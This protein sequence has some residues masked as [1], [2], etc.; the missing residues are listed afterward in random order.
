VSDRLARLGGADLAVLRRVPSAR[1]R[2]VQMALVLLTTAGVAV[3]S[4]SFALHDGVKAPWAWAVLFGLLWGGVIL[5]IDRF[6]VTS[7]GAI[8]S[9]WQ[10]AFMAL[11]RLAMAAL[12]SLAISTPLVLRVFSS[13]IKAEVYSQQLLRSRQQATQIANSKESQEAAGLATQIARYQAVLN[14]HLP[15]SVTSPALQQAQL[16]VTALTT[17]Q[18]QAQNARDIAYEAWQ[19]ELYGAGPTCQGASDRTG[20][21]PLAGAKQREY[22]DAEA[23][24][25]ALTAQLQQ[26][27]SAEQGASRQMQTAQ[28]RALAAAQQNARSRL[29]ALQSRYAALEADVQKISNQGTSLNFGDT[30]LLAQLQAL[31]KLSSQSATLLAAH[32]VVMALFFLIEILPVT[33]KVLLNVQPLTAYEI[34]AHARDDKSIEKIRARQNEARRIAE[35]R[36]RARLAVQDDK[37]QQEVAAGKLANEYVAAEQMRILD[38]ALQQWKSELQTRLH[39][40]WPAGAAR[41]RPSP[42]PAPPGPAAPIS[43]VVRTLNGHPWLPGLEDI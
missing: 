5:N 6:L 18:Q 30:G 7:M 2:F 3:V 12:L 23:H 35:G 43:T 13:D 36:T 37:R 14:G 31:S 15:D 28:A 27:T 10:L 1:S 8:R 32:L 38:I 9:K 24:F 21:G 34:V 40:D 25:E 42:S 41:S 39:V 26:A 29:P 11:P 4:M 16:Q 33:V 20:A 19:C 22:A 17:Q